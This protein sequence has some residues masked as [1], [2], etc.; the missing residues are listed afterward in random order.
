MRTSVSRLRLAA[1]LLPALCA[2]SPAFA[3]DAS[4]DGYSGVY[5]GGAFGMSVQSN[6]QGS[7]IE[8]DRNLD[9]TFGDTV[10]TAAGANAFSPGFCNG[11]AQ[12]ARPIDGCTNDDDGIDYAVRAGFDKQFGRIVAGVVGEFGRAEITDNVSAFTTTPAS[13][14]MTREV[15]YLAA[16]RARVGFTPQGT[17]LFYA[18]GGGA[19]ARIKGKFATTNTVNAFDTNGKYNV[20]GFQAG[21]GVEQKITDNISIGLEYLYNDFKD[22]KARVFVRQG[23]APGTNPFLL[24]GA[25][26]TD[27]RRSDNNFRWHTGRVTV[28]FRF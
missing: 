22:K 11:T 12:G 15:D 4:E 23:A 26:G 28:N 2:A 17:T 25:G 1:V 10:V 6:D 9:G 19:Y 20:Y 5:I 7:I 27:F 18:T 16:L 13:Y 8:F 14:R 24:A 21:G 3:Q